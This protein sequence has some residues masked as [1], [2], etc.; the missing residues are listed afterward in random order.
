MRKAIGA[1]VGYN[2]WANHR[3]LDAAGALEPASFT[4]EV[5]REFS[6]PTLQGML[7]HLMGA[8]LIWLGRWQGDSP[9]TP[10]RAEDYPTLAA[11][12]SRWES[13]ERDFRR[14]VDGLGDEELGRVVETRTLA[15]QVYQLPLWQMIQHVVNH[16]THHRSE[17]ATMLTRLGAP[18]PPL[19]LVIYYRR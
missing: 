18:P 6:F 4:Q 2:Y 16:G 7:V 10:Q 3:V 13:A 5:G 17:V 19:D 8:E 11:L 9:G 15:G 12:R 1:V 14:F